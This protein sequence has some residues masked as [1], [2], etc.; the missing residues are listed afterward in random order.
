MGVINLDAKGVAMLGAV[1]VGLYWLAKQ[2]VKSVA[3]AINP[4]DQN[5]VINTGFNSIYA[6]LTDGKG[7]LGTDIYDFFHPTADDLK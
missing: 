4:A 7:T 1:A 3:A 2:E 6:S 5:N